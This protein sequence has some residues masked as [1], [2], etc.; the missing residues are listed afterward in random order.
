MKFKFSYLVAFAATLV[1]GC[2]AYYSVFGL[3]QLFAGASLAV[4]LMASSLEFS[5]VI[6]VSL[7]EK[8]WDKLGKALRIYLIVGVTI[9]VCITSAGIYGFLSNAY[10][11]TASNVEMTDAALSVIN[12][13]K[14]LFEKNITDNQKI[15]ETKTSRVSQ[16]SN[17]RTIQEGRIDAATTNSNKG[18]ARADIDASSKEVQ[19]LNAE[20]DV[21]NAKNAVL[22]DSVNVYANKA[23][24]VKSKSNSTS[25]I[26]PL[27]YLAQLT[28]YPMDKIINWFILL[29]IF[30]FDPLAV[31]LVV[32][33]NKVLEIEKE[34]VEDDGLYVVNPQPWPATP[35]YD[36]L[37]KNTIE[38]EPKIPE[39]PEIEDYEYESEPEIP[40][41]EPPY[42]SDDFQIGPDGAYEH[43][44]EESVI[45]EPVIEEPVAEAIIEEPV[46]EEPVIEEPVVEA[47]IEEPV[48]EPTVY[49]PDFVIPTGKIEVEDIKEKR[50]QTNR[51]FSTNI[52]HP[53]NMVERITP[54]KYRRS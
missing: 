19:T 50:Q 5:K 40:F 31:A 26:G 45:E 9:L 21:L 27:K 33:T 13:K 16:L 25:E 30:V 24:E 10:Q 52:P 15:I 18:R 34:D 47:I 54:N 1:A 22:S 3:S 39:E 6:A 8:Y 53:T 43:I 36:I 46:I 11:K 17:L 42:V 28:G 51:G 37:T 23:I 41:E 44:E 4:I 14:S 29:L 35:M 32:A 48:I 12:N 49:K 2:A 7:L 38:E 20:I